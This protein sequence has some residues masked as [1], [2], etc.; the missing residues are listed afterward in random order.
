VLCRRI[1]ARLERI[2]EGAGPL[3]IQKSV[4]AHAIVRHHEAEPGRLIDWMKRR[5]VAR[6]RSSG[7][8]QAAI[9]EVR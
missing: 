4:K 2:G 6:L 1:P 7:A 8:L 5:R 3:A 9:A